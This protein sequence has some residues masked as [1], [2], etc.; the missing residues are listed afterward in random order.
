[1]KSGNQILPGEMGLKT[2]KG[3]FFSIIWNRRQGKLYPKSGAGMHQE[4]KNG[5]VK[6]MI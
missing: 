1:M 5:N 6:K 3:N 4:G 2:E